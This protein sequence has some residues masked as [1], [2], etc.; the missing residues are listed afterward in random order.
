MYLNAP[1]ELAWLPLFSVVLSVA[2]LFKRP[3]GWPVLVWGILATPV[4]VVLIEIAAMPDKP[5]AFALRAAASAALNILWFVYF[6][7]RR[8][9]FGASRRWRWLEHTFPTVVGPESHPSRHSA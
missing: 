1:I 8:A 9:M 6:Y 3:W 7:R 5:F 2:A 4:I